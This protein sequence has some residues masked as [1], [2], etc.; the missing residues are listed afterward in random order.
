MLLFDLGNTRLKFARGSAGQ[1]FDLRA[2][3]LDSAEADAGLAGVLAGA[4][5]PGEAWIASVTDPSR[6]E[7]LLQRL[8]GAGVQAHCLGPP[9][10]DELLQLAYA[11][12]EQ[13]G[14]DRWLALRA[15]RREQRGAF[16]L[17]SVGSAL[18]IDAVDAQGRHLGG[19]IAPSP[20]RALEALWLRAP[21]LRGLPGRVDPFACN[22]ADGVQSG[23]VLAAAA[24]VERLHAEAE[25]RLD[26]PVALL[27]TG[28]GAPALQE[29]IHA[30]LQLREQ[31]V[32]L[33]LLQWAEHASVVSLPGLRERPP[34]TG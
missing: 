32:L 29:W 16:V 11:Q 3:P 14:V 7:A 6:R 20:E 12:P 28:G 26:Q 13:F 9:R 1:L 17:A 25:H 24:L 5:G 23:A 27:L 15:L 19:V 18:T 21:H 34:R 4:S 8:R 30:P 10:S 33:G 2:W 22:T 31:L